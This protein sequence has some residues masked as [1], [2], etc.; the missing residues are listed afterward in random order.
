MKTDNKE[1]GFFFF[2]HTETYK[3]CSLDE[4]TSVTRRGRVQHFFFP[5]EYILSA[6]DVYL[7]EIAGSNTVKLIFLL[8][9]NEWGFNLLQQL[10]LGEDDWQMERECQKQMALI[11]MKLPQRGLTVLRFI[12][13]S[14]ALWTCILSE[15]E[16]YSWTFWKNEGHSWPFPSTLGSNSCNSH[17]EARTKQI[18]LLLVFENSQSCWCFLWVYC[19]FFCFNRWHCDLSTKQKKN[20]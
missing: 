9:V 3:R 7:F 2:L 11:F 8:M 15:V 10:S 4:T 14:K 18:I 13:E 1:S 19:S 12:L 17:H 16:G 6:V 20:S 5:W